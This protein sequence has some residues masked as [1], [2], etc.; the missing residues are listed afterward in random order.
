MF[1]PYFM[2]YKVADLIPPMANVRRLYV[3]APQPR[4]T[5]KGQPGQEDGQRLSQSV[6]LSWLS[7]QTSGNFTQVS[8]SSTQAPNIKAAA[9]ILHFLF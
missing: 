3:Q 8:E 5:D 1:N 7:W 6:S 9:I 2:L 4:E